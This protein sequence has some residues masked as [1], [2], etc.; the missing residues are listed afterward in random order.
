MQTIFG[1]L[2]KVG[3]EDIFVHNVLPVLYKMS[4]KDI[5]RFA[6][7]KSGRGKNPAPGYENMPKEQRLWSAYE[8]VHTEYLAK[9]AHLKPV[10]EVF[11]DLFSEA[12]DKYPIGESKTIRLIDFCRRDVAECAMRTLLGPT[13][14]KLNPGFLDAF[15]EFDDKVFMLT[16]GF[17]KWLYPRPYKVHDRYL[18]MIEQ[19]VESARSNFDWD[20]PSAESPWEPHFG[21]RVCRE[22][23]K[24]LQESG[25]AD[26]SIA[27]ALGTLLF[28]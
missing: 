27:G 23:A 2:N 28:A 12:L 4:K 19:Y 20:G 21:A 8:H 10:I 17:P 13:I 18:G 16:L 3:S 22:I 6:D 14:F 25:F 5:E 9:T 24:W 15:W 7:D 11:H 26:V 1:R